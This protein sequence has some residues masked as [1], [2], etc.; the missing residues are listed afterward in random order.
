MEPVKVQAPPLPPLVLLVEPLVLPC[1]P[2]LLEAWLDPVAPALLLELWA[3][4]EV[5]VDPPCVPSTH[6]PSALQVP[7]EQSAST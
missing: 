2:L 7:T 6:R 3:L 4:C 1:P 5:P